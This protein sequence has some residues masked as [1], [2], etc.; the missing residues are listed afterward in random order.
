MRIVIES[1]PHD[2]Q[3][4]ETCGDYTTDADGALHIRV[5]HTEDDYDFLI[6]VHELI[7]AYLCAKRGITGEEIDAFDFAFERARKEGNF[8]EPGNNPAAPYFMEHKFATAIE[9]QVSKELGVKW[10]VYDKTIN[11]L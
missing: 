7:E 3:R 10:A 6:A 8:D 4:Y 5:S 9:R 11:A 1:I 2:Q